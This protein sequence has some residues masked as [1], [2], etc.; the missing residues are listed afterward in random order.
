M[1]LYV[2]IQK[3]L[4]P[5]FL[6]VSM[7]T[8]GGVT[9]LLGASG[10]GKS[11]TLMCIAGIVKPDKGT[12]VLNNRTLF[13]SK[14]HINL[15]PQHRRVGYLFQHYALFPH[16][17]V[18]QN[19][20]CG[21]RGKKDPAR[22][23]RS[24]REIIELM[25]L[26]GLEKRLP[27]QLSQGQQQRVALARILVGAPELLMLDEP[28]SAL[29]SQLR[30]QLQAETQKLLRR[31]GEEAL[32]VT[33]SQ[34]EAYHLC[35]TIALLDAGKL[36]ACRETK[37]LFADPQ[38]RQAALLIGC[39]N[40]VS[41]Q[42]AGAYTV[43]IPDWGVQFVTS[44]P[45]GDDLRAVG[46]GARCFD[47]QTEHNRLAVRFSNEIAGPFEYHAQF[48]FANQAA[49]TPD[50]WWS[51]PQDKKRGPFPAELGLAPSDIMLLYK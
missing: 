48:R 9:G 2:D 33:H 13:D 30:F 50:I 14:R 37:E 8:E 5:F 32:L 34:E 15:S 27:R 21:L 10:S 6:D 22:K 38:S 49:K 12:I 44:R 7:T 19:I 26:S 11:M 3:R 42:K 35:H 45:V 29:D 18:Q 17:T 24:L 20:L 40:V 46:V 47:P 43:A 51:I 36:F 1:S 41:A 39:K 16:M 23:E 25:Q 4:G 28:F 31:F